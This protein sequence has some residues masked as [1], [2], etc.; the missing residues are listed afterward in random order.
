MLYHTIRDRLIEFRDEPTA[1]TSIVAADNSE[2]FVVP[3]SN[4]LDNIYGDGQSERGNSRATT[5]L[6]VGKPSKLPAPSSNSNVPFH[7]SSQNL[8]PALPVC[9]N[10]S[11]TKSNAESRRHDFISTAKAALGWTLKTR[12]FA[13]K[14]TIPTLKD[15]STYINLSKRH[16]PRPSGLPQIPIVD[17]VHLIADNTAE[18][19]I[20][21][22]MYEVYNDRIF[23]LLGGNIGQMKNG[24]HR[25]RALLFKST[26]QSPDRKVVAGLKKVVCGS[27]E[28]AMMVLETG[29]MERKVAG[30]GSNAVSSRSH[31][32]FCLEVKKRDRATKGPWSGSTMT[33]V[34][35]AG[36]AR[37][38]ILHSKS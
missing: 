10:T 31:G 11:P 7:N 28:E 24:P 16:I 1:F 23:D 35:L 30:T 17:N 3:A 32:F 37:D 15:S 6:L 9:N 14:E 2:A 26:E 12:S 36:M 34:D 18:Y 5:P 13:N 27:F 33:V 4:F 22:S 20:V 8:Y 25:R 38:F 21:V 19:A 29:L